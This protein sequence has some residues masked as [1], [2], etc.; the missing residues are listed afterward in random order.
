MS[1]DFL[2]VSVHKPGVVEYTIIPGA[3]EARGKQAIRAS[4]GNLAGCCIKEAWREKEGKET[5]RKDVHVQRKRICSKSS[6]V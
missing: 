1:G 6:S 2:K 3:W 5:E 4:L